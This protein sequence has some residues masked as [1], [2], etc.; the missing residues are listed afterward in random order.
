MGC[1][2]GGKY[3]VV[4]CFLRKEYSA[5]RGQARW[6]AAKGAADQAAVAT[7]EWIMMGEELGNSAIILGDRFVGGGHGHFVS[8]QQSS[9]IPDPL[10][11]PLRC[12][13]DD[14]IPQVAAQP[15]G[16]GFIA[17]PTRG[18]SDWP[19]LEHVF[20]RYSSPVPLAGFEILDGKHRATSRDRTI[21]N[22]YLARGKHVWV[23]GVGEVHYL[24]LA[25]HDWGT[26]ART[27]A[28][29]P[30][31]GTPQAG[32]DS[33]SGGRA[34][35]DAL[36]AGRMIA[37]NGPVATFR[38]NGQ[39]LGS[40]IGAIPGET[41]PLDAY[42]KTHL[43]TAL[44]ELLPVKLRFVFEY[45]NALGKTVDRSFNVAL[46]DATQQRGT[47]HGS[48]QIPDGFAHGFVRLEASSAER[49]DANPLDIPKDTFEFGQART[50]FTNPIFL[51]G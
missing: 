45:V 20:D 35:K 10:P 1:P 41:L 50:A 26:R 12:G 14:C 43:S 5:Q 17:H 34:I 30:G 29:V 48:L 16:F 9:F 15:G 36:K 49:L 46:D 24:E 47:W 28:Y 4:T 22:A 51:G 7:G 3:V 32:Y 2:A 27:Y 44:H 38:I 23:V 8:Y 31:A 21:W 40:T 18:G 19:D 13:R 33:I 39:D 37:T 11:L 6:I 42:W 25:A